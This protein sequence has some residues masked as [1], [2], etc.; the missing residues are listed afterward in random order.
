MMKRRERRAPSVAVMAEPGL[1]RWKRKGGGSGAG[2]PG[3]RHLLR[4]KTYKVWPVMVQVA[5]V[6]MGDKA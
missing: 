1:D 4:R 6:P 2:R 3:Y 5:F